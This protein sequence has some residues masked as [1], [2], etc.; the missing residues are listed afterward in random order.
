MCIEDDFY[1]DKQINNYDWIKITFTGVINTSKC[2]FG[3]DY[4][5]HF[6]LLFSLCLLLFMDF[7]VIFDTI[8][9]SHC[10]ILIKFYFYLSYFSFSKIKVF[11]TDRLTL[12]LTPH[13]WAL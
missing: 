11:Q 3:K 10:T 1:Y 5:C 13:H 2:S 6:I 7:T 4:F 12:F 8:Y 9:R